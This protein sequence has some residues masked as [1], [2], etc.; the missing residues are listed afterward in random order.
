[1]TPTESDIRKT[2]LLIEAKLKKPA[3]NKKENAAL[4]EGYTEA[5]VILAEGRTTYDGI[6]RLKTQQGRAIAVL[7]VDYLLGTQKQKVLCGVPLR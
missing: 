7:A 4:K 1:M 2:R 5:L 3:I 6:D